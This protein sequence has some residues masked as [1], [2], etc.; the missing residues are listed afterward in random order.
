MPKPKLKPRVPLL[1]WRIIG[2]PLQFAFYRIDSANP[3]QSAIYQL[4]STEDGKPSIVSGLYDRAQYEA[5]AARVVSRK[6][7]EVLTNA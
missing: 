6:D 2:R 7:C 1:R 5:T 4:V 3:F